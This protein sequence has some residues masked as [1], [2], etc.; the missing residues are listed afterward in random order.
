MHQKLADKLCFCSTLI[1]LRKESE[2]ET[3]ISSHTKRIPEISGPFFPL[4]SN[5]LE[6]EQILSTSLTP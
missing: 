1:S 2:K 3:D 4:D 5:L 6:S